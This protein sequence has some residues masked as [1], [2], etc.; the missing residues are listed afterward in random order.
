MNRKIVIPLMIIGFLT[1]ASAIS[2]GAVPGVNDLGEVDRGKTYEV[3]FYLTTSAEQNVVVKPEIGPPLTSI[4]FP[5]QNRGYDFEPEHASE[6]AIADWVTFR[7]EEFTANPE[8]ETVVNL[9]DGGARVNGKITFDLKIPDNAEP[10]YHA[11]SIDLHPELA[12][13]SGPQVVTLGV[14]QPTVVFEVPGRAE[15]SLE[16]MRVN[17]LR[18]GD[19]RA[20]IDLVVRNTGTVTTSLHDGDLQ[21]LDGTGTK[22]TDLVPGKRRIKPGEVEVFQTSW[23]NHPNDIEA[24]EYIVRGEANYITGN[25]LVDETINIRDF[26]EIQQTENRTG[27]PGGEKKETL[28]TWLILMLLILLGVIMYSFDIDPV[29]IVMIVGFAAISA[30]VLIMGLPTYLI[31]IA[32]IMMAAVMYFG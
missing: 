1:Q 15:R 13:G 6:E 31:V 27:E 3:N 10:G 7:Q 14:T 11:A 22:M 25:A 23:D 9:E 30:F 8:E 32:L 20:R 5:S 4:M 21:V 18:S 26:I 29:W 12:G 17:G 24:G 16:V 28:P 19:G 2:V